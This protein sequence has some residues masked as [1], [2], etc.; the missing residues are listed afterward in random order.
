SS[1]IAA[2]HAPL[3]SAVVLAA[4]ATVTMLFGLRRRPGTSSRIV[5][6]ATFVLLAAVAFLVPSAWS[7]AAAIAAAAALVIHL[8]VGDR[9]RVEPRATG[10]GSGR[11]GAIYVG[12]AL[13]AA[14]IMLLHDLGGYAGS[15][16]RWEAP[17][18]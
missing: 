12:I 5:P 3:A 6:G 9:E 2:V 17:V 15:L 7:R 11:V 16:Q 18:V 10:D 13:L 4:G 14:A 1:F 8:V